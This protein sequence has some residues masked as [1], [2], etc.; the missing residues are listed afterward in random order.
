MGIS[1]CVCVCVYVLFTL[2]SL[3]NVGKTM[4]MVV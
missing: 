4:N 1:V 3:G 2:V